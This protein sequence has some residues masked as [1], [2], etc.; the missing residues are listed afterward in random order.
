[1][2]ISKRPSVRIAIA[3]L[4]L[5]AFL[6]VYI[7]LVEPNLLEVVWIQELEEPGVRIVFFADLHMWR[8][9]SFHDR[10]LVT[11]RDL[12]PDLILFGGDALAKW[13]VVPDMERFFDELRHISQVWAIF[14]NWEEYAPVHMRKRYENLGVPLLEMNSEILEINGRRIGLTGLESPYFFHRTEFLDPDESFDARILLV[15]AP[16]Q[17]ERYPQIVSGY[18]YVLAAHTHGGQWYIPHLTEWVLRVTGQ[19]DYRFFRGLYEWEEA[20]IFVTRGIGQWLPGRFNSVPE[21]AVLDL[22]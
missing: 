5:A 11:I 21:I 13:T 16:N 9:R 10:V 17:L 7:F 22:P 20:I 1:M 18:D 14:G 2:R 15:H 4:V 12:N 8:Y 19:G 3:I 6:C